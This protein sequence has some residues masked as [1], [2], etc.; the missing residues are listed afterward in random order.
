M[1]TDI[2]ELRATAGEGYSLTTGAAAPTTHIPT[3]R[4][5]R[6]GR[7]P[8]PP[9]ALTQDARYTAYFRTWHKSHRVLLPAEAGTV[10][11]ERVVDDTWK[12][13]ASNNGATDYVFQCWNR[14]AMPQNDPVY[15]LTSPTAEVTLDGDAAYTAYYVPQQVTGGHLRGRPG[16]QG[17]AAGDLPPSMRGPASPCLSG[18]RTTLP[19][20]EKQPFG[21][22]RRGS[23]RRRPGPPPSWPRRTADSLGW[24]VPFPWRCGPR[25]GA[26]HRRGLDRRL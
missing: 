11:A 25:G 9:P 23:G 21:G 10:S 1:E 15:R 20:F 19:A 14:D 22:V 12:L 2:Y 18:S 5:I 8:I 24:A 17:S 7:T 3:T 13:T 4:C 26:D 6:S 16:L